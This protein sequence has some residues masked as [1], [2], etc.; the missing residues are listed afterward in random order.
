M[1]STVGNHFLGGRPAERL[2]NVLLKLLAKGLMDPLHH[3]RRS[4]G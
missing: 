4:Q 3:L 2:E 1:K